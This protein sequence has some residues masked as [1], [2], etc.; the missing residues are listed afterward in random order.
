MSLRNIIRF[1]FHKTAQSTLLI[2]NYNKC[3]DIALGFI[4]QNCEIFVANC[5][6]QKVRKKHFAKFT[7][8]NHKEKCHLRKPNSNYNF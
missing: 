4:A 8:M 2:V 3:N 7:A 5:F 6:T 1:F